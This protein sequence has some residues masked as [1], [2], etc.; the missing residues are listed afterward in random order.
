MQAVLE[1]RQKQLSRAPLSAPAQSQAENWL[2]RCDRCGQPITYDEL[3]QVN[4]N[5]GEMEVTHLKCPR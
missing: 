4:C 3:L 1:R 2:F 5:G